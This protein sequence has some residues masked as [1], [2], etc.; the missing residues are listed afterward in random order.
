MSLL[1]VWGTQVETL[2]TATRGREASGTEAGVRL[3]VL[4]LCIWATNL[5][6]Q[7]I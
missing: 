7:Q 2:A 3:R 5:L 1:G 6:K 4:S